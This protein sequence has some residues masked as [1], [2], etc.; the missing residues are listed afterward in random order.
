MGCQWS[1]ICAIAGGNHHLSHLSLDNGRKYK[2]GVENQLD[3]SSN[4]ALYCADFF[5][6][7]SDDC[8]LGNYNQVKRAGL[9]VERSAVDSFQSGAMNMNSWVLFLQR[10]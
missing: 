4:T 3:C 10:Q 6:K 7:Y 5:Y 9:M 1:R 8:P 2:F